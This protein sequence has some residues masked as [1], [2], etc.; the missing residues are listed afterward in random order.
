MR[1]P[2]GGCCVWGIKYFCIKK[3]ADIDTGEILR[4]VE[5]SVCIDPEFLLV[6][7][8]EDGGV[9]EVQTHKF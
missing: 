2:G 7:H 5:R 4:P 3:N 8:N 1:G 9:V 6:I